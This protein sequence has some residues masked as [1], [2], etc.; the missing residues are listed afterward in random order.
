MQILRK[1]AAVLLSLCILA[2][3]TA[4]AAVELNPAEMAAMADYIA[5]RTEGESYAV[6]LALAAVLLNQLEDPRYPDTVSGILAREGYRALR[7]S[8]DYPSARAALRAAL[9]GLDITDGA[10]AWARRGTPAGVVP[11]LTLGEWVF[12]EEGWGPSY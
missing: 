5:L 6:R 7:R 12:G 11:H 10:V 3:P 8:P 9:E 4:A 2:A 1:A